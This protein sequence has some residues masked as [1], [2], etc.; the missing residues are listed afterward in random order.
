MHLATKIYALAALE[1]L[2]NRTTR[3]KVAGCSHPPGVG[4]GA[5]NSW[6]QRSRPSVQSSLGTGWAHHEGAGLM[7]A[8]RITEVCAERDCLLDLWSPAQGLA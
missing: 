3:L 7:A 2:E 6:Y 1:L 8:C 4:Y 5:G